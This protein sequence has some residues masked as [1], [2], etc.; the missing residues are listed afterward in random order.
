MTV[1][2][3]VVVAGKTKIGNDVVYRRSRTLAR[4]AILA[5]VSETSVPDDGAEPGKFVSGITNKKGASDLVGLNKRLRGSRQKQGLT[6]GAMLG[7]P[8]PTS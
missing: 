1:K 5:T 7:R 3:Y 2:R 8:S 6:S 4:S